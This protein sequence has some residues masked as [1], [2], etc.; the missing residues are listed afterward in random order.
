V[1]SRTDRDN[2]RPFLDGAKRANLAFVVTFLLFATIAGRNYLTHNRKERDEQRADFTSEAR[3]RQLRLAHLLE[4]RRA[5]LTSIVAYFGTSTQVS[6]EKFALY[7]SQLGPLPLDAM[8]WHSLDRS[9]T[10]AVGFGSSSAA[11]CDMFDPARPSQVYGDGTDAHIILSQYART[12]ESGQEGHVSM[13]MP[14]TSLALEDGPHDVVERLLVEDASLRSSAS[15]RLGNDASTEDPPDAAPNANALLFDLA[16]FDDMKMRYAAHPGFHHTHRSAA[17]LLFSISVVVV[18]LLAGAYLRNLLSTRTK[19]SEQVR[20]KTAELSQFAYRTT[21]DLRGPLVTVAGLCRAMREDLEQGQSAEALANVG[22]IEQR[23][24]RLDTLVRDILD[25]T[26]ADV[27]QFQAEPVDLG[28]LVIE[29]REHVLSTVGADQVR[30]EHSVTAEKPVN[31]PRTRLFQILNNLLSNSIKYANP[32]REP[33]VTVAVRAVPKHLQLTVED[34]GLGI[35][36][37]YH[38]RLFQMFERFHPGVKAVGS[39]L[40]MSIVKR[41]VDHLGGTIEVVSN[42]SGTKIHVDIPLASD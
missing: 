10:F 5:L 38:D 39:G 8:C 3:N 30:V 13:V 28:E 24:Q 20:I 6:N 29:V 21:H 23:I 25:M 1:S 42:T 35:P 40:G 2:Q 37:Q 36:E 4:S 12:R 27:G 41:H 9:K 15:F 16:Q 34:N 26:R 32:S 22:R 31:L 18:G 14:V 19:I 33:H 7:A 17:E 11:A